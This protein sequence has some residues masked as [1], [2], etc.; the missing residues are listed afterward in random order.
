MVR[1]FFR[2]WLASAR[3]AG[4]VAAWQEGKA[5][6]PQQPHTYGM[7]FHDDF[8]GFALLQRLRQLAKRFRR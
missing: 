2:F 3:R 8:G 5:E 1:A 6:T 4:Q 7:E